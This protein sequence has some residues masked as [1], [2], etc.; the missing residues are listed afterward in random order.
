MSI[1]RN[2]M[3]SLLFFGSYEFLFLLSTVIPEIQQSQPPGIY[4]SC[5]AG[6][7]AHAQLQI[8]VRVAYVANV[9]SIFLFRL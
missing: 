7:T 6:Y 3:I 2:K 8:A 9:L 5:L 4:Y 1:L